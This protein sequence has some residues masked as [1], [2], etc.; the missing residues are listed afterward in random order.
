[1]VIRKT[2]SC[3]LIV[4]LL[5]LTGNVFADSAII[6]IQKNYPRDVLAKKDASTIER[7]DFNFEEDGLSFLYTDPR[8]YILGFVYEKWNLKCDF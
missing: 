2:I 6:N 8:M 5:F 7:F 1:M 3:F 4:G